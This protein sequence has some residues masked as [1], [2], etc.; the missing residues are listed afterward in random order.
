MSDDVVV[1]VFLGHL[2]STLFMT[3]VIWF[4]QV[5]HYPLFTSVSP[6]GFAA[7]EVRHAALTTGVVA[8]AMLTEA[9][10]A[11][12]LVWLRP[13]GVAAAHLW[14]ALALLAVIWLSTAFVQ[15]PLHQRLGRAF[16]PSLHRRL[17]SSNWVRTVAWSAR[18][19]LVLGMTRALAP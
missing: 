6:N 14:I 4:V 12:G 1:L 8:P 7:Y 5:V 13:P 15:V 11:L 17:V 16:D 18:A 3:G 2:G 9:I 10:T 19:V